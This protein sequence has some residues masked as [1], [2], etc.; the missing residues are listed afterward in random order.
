MIGEVYNDTLFLGHDTNN[1]PDT[2]FDCEQDE[3]EE[4]VPVGEAHDILK[5]FKCACCTYHT[6][7]NEFNRSEGNNENKYDKQLSKKNQ[8]LYSWTQIEEDKFVDAASTFNKRIKKKSKYTWYRV[9]IETYRKA[10]CLYKICRLK[11]RHMMP[12]NRIQQ[13]SRIG[14]K[15]YRKI[16]HRVKIIQLYLNERIEN[17]ISNY[18]TRDLRYEDH[19]AF[20]QD[21]D[22]TDMEKWYDVE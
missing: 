6:S 10:Y 9:L 22:P 15:A 13:I 18:K 11:M 3:Q 16:C 14:W 7:L 2:F 4:C 12:R 17:V 1:H 19:Y 8:K 21:T 20:E 5:G